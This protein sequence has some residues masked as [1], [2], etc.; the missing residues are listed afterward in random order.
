M[1]CNHWQADVYMRLTKFLCP[2]RTDVQSTREPHYAL[3]FTISLQQKKK[4]Y[5]NSDPKAA[6]VT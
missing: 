3:V 4:V 6:N 1:E 2:G 5:W